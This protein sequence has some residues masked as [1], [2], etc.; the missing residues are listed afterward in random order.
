MVRGTNWLTADRCDGT[1]VKTRQGVVAVV[2]LV[3]KKT[4]LVKAGKS[5]LA[6]KP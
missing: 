1:Y 2:D 5:Y 3:L 4:V 6:K